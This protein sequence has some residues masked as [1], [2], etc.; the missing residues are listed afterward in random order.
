[1]VLAVLVLGLPRRQQQKALRYGI[2]GAFAFRSLATA[3]S[4]LY[5]IRLALGE[6]GRR[7]CTC[8]TCRTSHFFGRRGRGGAARGRAGDGRGSA[9]RA[10]WATVVQGRADRHRLR[11]RLDPRRRGD[12]AEAVGDPDRRHPRHH[13]DAAGDRPAARRSSSAI[14]RS[15]TARSSSSRGSASSCWSSTCTSTGLIGWEVPKWLGSA[16]IVVIF[17]GALAWAI[18]DE[19]KRKSDS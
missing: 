7:R 10:F 12:V 19:R 13:R 2:L 3:A 5:L 11:G 14:R 17:A 15:W 1:M 9:C 16:S 4:P 18:W 8:C 6:A